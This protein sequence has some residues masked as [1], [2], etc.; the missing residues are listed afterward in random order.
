MNLLIIR[1]SSCKEFDSFIKKNEKSFV[2]ID[3]VYFK[4]LK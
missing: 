1:L 2:K 3:T 4:N